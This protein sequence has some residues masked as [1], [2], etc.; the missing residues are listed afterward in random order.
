MEKG[1]KAEEILEALEEVKEKISKLSKDLEEISKA[2]RGLG[3]AL[4][5][6][7]IILLE[8]MKI[9]GERKK[10][11]CSFYKEG[12]CRYHLSPSK[13][14]QLPFVL[15]SRKIRGEERWYID[16]HP[17]FCALCLFWRYREEHEEE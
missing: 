4:N 3:D 10:R 13:Y 17:F 11:S 14:L 9:V 7:N 8:T 1:D 16:P 5:K 2:T 6:E 15:N 12:F